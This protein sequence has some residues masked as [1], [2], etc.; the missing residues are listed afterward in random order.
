MLARETRNTSELGEA[1]NKKFLSVLNKYI[2][3]LSCQGFGMARREN[4]IVGESRWK[5]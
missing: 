1:F 4:T 5:L 2:L 3:M